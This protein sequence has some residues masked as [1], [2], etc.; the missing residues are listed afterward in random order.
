[1]T[2]AFSP[3]PIYRGTMANLPGTGIVLFGGK[4]TAGTN[5]Q[6]VG[7]TFLW[8]GTSWTQVSTT[9]GPPSARF[10]HSM[11]SDGTN[12][13]MVGG[14]DATGNL[15]SDTWSLS[16]S[17]VWALQTTT[18]YSAPTTQRR[19]AMAFMSSIGAFLF[20][21][22]CSFRK[23]KYIQDTWQWTH[24]G[25]WTLLIPATLPPG[26]ADTAMAS[27]STTLLMMGGKN[28]NGALADAFTFNGTTWTAIGG[29][30][31]A[32]YGHSMAYDSTNSKWVIF[33]GRGLDGTYLNDTWTYDGT[34]WV[35]IKP[36]TSPAGRAEAQMDFDSTNARVVLFGGIGY[37]QAYND[38]WLFNT[39]TSTWTQQ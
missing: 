12:L 3:P 33:G 8:N 32:R 29:G 22:E 1:M 5:N 26:R 14:T 25:G 35:N 31:T 27:S 7:N 16:S 15:L 6:F 36:A 13:I 30:P 19:T 11:T 17:N 24:S 10:D 28:F 38:T 4:T 18:P 39:A 2:L 21:G 37:S 23:G 20:G 34:S 9:G